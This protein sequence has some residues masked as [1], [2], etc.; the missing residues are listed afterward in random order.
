M[1]SLVRFN[2]SGSW[3]CPCS[4]TIRHSSGA[5]CK[6]INLGLKKAADCETDMVSKRI[7]MKVL[8]S[9]EMSLVALKAADFNMPMMYKGR[10]CS[11]S[12][13]GAML[14]ACTT[15]RARRRDW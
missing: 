6:A 2:I 4:F 10:N 5:L 3:I 12:D 1:D 8:R 11:A 14:P 9:A 15:Y 7:Q 13:W